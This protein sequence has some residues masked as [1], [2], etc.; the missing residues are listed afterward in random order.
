[1]STRRRA[2]SRSRRSRWRSVP[3]R[4]RADRSTRRGGAATRRTC[5][6]TTRA[7]VA[8]YEEVD[9]QGPSS[10]RRRVQPRRRL[11]P[12]GRAGPVDLGVRARARDRSERRRRPIQPG[13]GAQAGRPARAR[14]PR[15]TEGEDKEPAWMR[16]VGGV[17]PSTDDLV[18]RRRSTSASSRVLI[19][20]RW[21]RGEWRPALA[22][23][24]GRPGGGRAADRRAARRA[25]APGSHPV[26]RA[27]ARRGG[28]QGRRRHE[29]PHQLRRRTPAC[30]SAS[31][32]AI[33]TGC[34]SAWPTASKA[35]SEAQESADIGATVDRAEHLAV[36]GITRL[37]C[38]A[39]R[40]HGRDG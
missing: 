34:A 37:R 23:G 21:A 1:M 8:A 16:L 35:G 26:R 25:R 38:R 6:A 33:R 9:R 32:I 11:L 18:L 30:A 20:R 36:V 19:A 22:R 40:V 27:A 4:A 31:S 2:C 10:R 15:R 28:G 3:G 29:L 13:Q 17:A 7:P 39:G 14:S 5:T 12:Q 24:R